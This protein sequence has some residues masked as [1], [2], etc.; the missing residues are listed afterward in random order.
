M[1]C[2]MLLDQYA[3]RDYI[4]SNFWKTSNNLSIGQT[5]KWYFHAYFRGGVSFNLCVHIST[6]QL[7]CVWNYF[8]SRINYHL[9]YRVTWRL[10]SKWRRKQQRWRR[11]RKMLFRD[12]YQVDYVPW[13]KCLSFLLYEIIYIICFRIGSPTE[14]SES[15]QK[16]GML[17][18]PSVIRC[19]HHV[20]VSCRY[21]HVVITC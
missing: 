1:Q 19:I 8:F 13:L 20:A 9:S 6:W 21:I 5:K 11:V 4:E 12:C 16:G 15:C 14:A 18:H 2:I 7:S 3:T 10:L 17:M